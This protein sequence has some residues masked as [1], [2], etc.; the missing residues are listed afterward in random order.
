MSAASPRENLD[1]L[2]G[3]IRRSLALVPDARVRDE[4]RAATYSIETLAMWHEK[5]CEQDIW[6]GVKLTKCHARLVGALRARLGQT[7]SKDALM[8]AIYFDRGGEEPE[9]KIL[10]IFICKL[11]KIITPETTGHEIQTVWGAGFRLVKAGKSEIAPAL[12]Q[13]LEAA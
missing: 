6:P 5:P 8:Y 9:P 13:A 1:E 4:A 10:D 11:R 7:V 12:L 2:L 3:K